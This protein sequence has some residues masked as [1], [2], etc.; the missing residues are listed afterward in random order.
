MTHKLK[1]ERLSCNWGDILYSKGHQ[2]VQGFLWALSDETK[3]WA[4]QYTKKELVSHQWWRAMPD[5]SGE[6]DYLYWQSRDHGKGAMPV[7]VWNPH[8]E[9]ELGFIDEQNG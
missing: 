9:S 1:I 5:S 3:G 2:D 4:T 7:T 6:Y 8:G